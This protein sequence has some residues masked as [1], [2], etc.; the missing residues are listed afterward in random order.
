M[1]KYNR[2]LRPQYV[3][4][5]CGTPTTPPI[6]IGDL[7]NPQGRDSTT[8]LTA[9]ASWS[10]IIQ[11]CIARIM[12]L[13]ECVT[14]HCMAT[15]FEFDTTQ[16]QYLTLYRE[17]IRHCMAHVLYIAIFDVLPH[18]CMSPHG[19]DTAKQQSKHCTAKMYSSKWCS[20]TSQRS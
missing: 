2:M 10:R 9:F 20:L 16:R 19:E 12:H 8:N 3:V 6:N 14:T 15:I 5:Q 18:H 1:I 13:M 17:H 11:H 4:D 7:I